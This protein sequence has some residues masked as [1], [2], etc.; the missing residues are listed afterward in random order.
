[1]INDIGDRIMEAKWNEK[2][3]DRQKTKRASAR[4]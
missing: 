1:M 4:M 3:K 2:V